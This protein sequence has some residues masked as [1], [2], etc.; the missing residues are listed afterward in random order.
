MITT[1]C[2]DHYFTGKFVKIQKDLRVNFVIF[3]IYFYNYSENL[4][5]RK[6]KVDGCK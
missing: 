2:K 5:R 3:V 4:T 6:F 1:P